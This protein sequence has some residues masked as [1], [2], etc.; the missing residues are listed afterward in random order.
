MLVIPTRPVN[1][2]N[3]DEVG[4]IEGQDSISYE[5]VSHDF[6]GMVTFLIP[7]Y[8]FKLLLLRQRGGWITAFSLGLFIGNI[9][10]RR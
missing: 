8:N 9:A 1:V 5:V 2:R 3:P 7:L 4:W 10:N 6:T